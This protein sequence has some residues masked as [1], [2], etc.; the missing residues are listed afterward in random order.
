MWECKD[1]RWTVAFV[2]CFDP[3]AGPP[4]DAGGDGDANDAG[5][6]DGGSCDGPGDDET[7]PIARQ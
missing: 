7:S 3:G 5:D 6:G 4:P 2:D 1:G